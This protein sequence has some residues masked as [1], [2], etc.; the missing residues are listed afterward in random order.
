MPKDS[1]WPDVYIV[2]EKYLK[3]S[4]EREKASKATA[5]EP[6]IKSKFNFKT[7]KEIGK[8]NRKGFINKATGF[9]EDVID[10]VSPDIL[11]SD[12]G[13]NWGKNSAKPKKT[14]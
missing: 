5:I 13:I 8:G 9:V 4:F 11:E 3:D 10:M 12:F 1:R 2:K 6:A 14:E 7:A